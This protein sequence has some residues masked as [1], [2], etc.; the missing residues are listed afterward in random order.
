MKSSETTR[1]AWHI[2]PEEVEEQRDR[3]LESRAFGHADQLRKLLAYLF[4]HTL[5]NDHH[6]VTQ[7]MIASDVLG[8]ADFDSLLDSSVRRLAGRLRER[9]R[10]YYSGEG[11]DDPLSSRSPKANLTGS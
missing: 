11:H 4:E 8:A 1:I 2:S 9:L 5:L 3:V 6:R 7:A 10:D